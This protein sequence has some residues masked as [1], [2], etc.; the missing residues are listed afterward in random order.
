MNY[1][2]ELVKYMSDLSKEVESKYKSQKINMLNDKEKNI[3]R[4]YSKIQKI[5]KENYWRIEYNEIFYKQ[6]Q[7]LEDIE[8]ENESENESKDLQYRTIYIYSNFSNA[9]FKEYLSWRTKIRKGIFELK[10]YQYVKIYISELLN[11]IGCIDEIEAIDKLIYFWENWRKLESKIDKT[12]PNV[13]KDFYIINYIKINKPYGEILKKYPIKI[14]SESTDIKE[15]EKGIYKNKINFLNDISKYKIEKSKL[16]ETE[17]G[18]LVEECI[19]KVFE[20]I[21][22]KSE[23]KR[24][25]LTEILI[26]KE[27]GESWYQPLRNYYIKDYKYSHK[28]VIINENEQY[29]YVGNRYWEKTGYVK[30]NQYNYIVAYIL[31]TIECHIRDYVGY[32]KL[33]MPEESEIEKGLAENGYY[34]S[35]EEKNIVLKINKMKIGEIIEKEIIKYLEKSRIPKLALRK[36]KKKQEVNEFDIE[37]KIE[38]VF[39]KEQFSKIREKSQITQKSLIIEEQ[40]EIIPKEQIKDEVKEEQIKEITKEEIK[41]VAKNQKEI[42]E[43]TSEEVPF[44]TE[45]IFKKFVYDLN[46]AEKEIIQILLKKEEP[47]SKIIEVAQKQN[48]MIEV[49]VSNINEKALETIGDNVIVPSLDSIYE[50]YEN[51][52]KQVI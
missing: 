6:A 44:A 16:L 10:E 51:E 15:I 8:Y 17:Y 25:D 11:K 45:D 2:E 13:I 5:E 12:I 35:R 21:H 39:N 3:N 36:K 34:Y 29:E 48:E 32:R 20:E 43:K 27:N 52:I 46:S 40:E 50:D 14:V 22:K 7:Y 30:Q 42:Q 31:K 24:I 1:L 9:N 37:E 18:Y 41:E 28:K 47:E 33:K 4:I 38:V 19:E 26:D 49:M 23:E